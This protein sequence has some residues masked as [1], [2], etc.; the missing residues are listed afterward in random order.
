MAI[1]TKIILLFIF[2]CLFSPDIYA[3]ENVKETPSDNTANEYMLDEVIVTGDSSLFSLRMEVYKAEEYKFE[4]FNSLNSTDEFDIKCE[5]IALTGSRIKRRVCEVGYIKEA[6]R[7]DTRKLRDHGIQP[8]SLAQLAAELAH[9]TKALNKEMT[10]L[11]I[12]HPELA[13]AMIRSHELNKLYLQEK[14]SRYKD[15]WLR[16]LAGNP[17]PIENKNILNEIDMWEKVFLDHLGGKL[18]DNIWARW[19]SWCKTKLQNKYYQKKWESANRDKYAD[20][21]IEYVNT[22]ISGK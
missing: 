10:A 3:K 14:T 8:R 20:E 13:T 6:R 17:E 18:R 7:E 19:D 21:F 1:K 4:I 2:P 16:Y 22:I 11:A 9:K 5:M 12:K 15:S